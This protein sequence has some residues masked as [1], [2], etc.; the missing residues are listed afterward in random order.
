M[1]N[2]E[3]I[4]YLQMISYLL[5]IGTYDDHDDVEEAVSMAIKALESQQWTLCSERLPEEDGYYFVALN[6]EWGKEVEAGFFENGR[7][8]NPNSHVTYAWMPIPTLPE[9]YMEDDDGRTNL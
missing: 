8:C 4:R 2:K 9:P 5:E 6:F 3:A 1:T 7:W